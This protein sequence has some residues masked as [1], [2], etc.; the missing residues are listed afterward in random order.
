MLK[1][2]CFQSVALEKTLEHPLDSKDM[3]PISL[4]GNQLWIFIGRTEAEASTLCPPDVKG[5]LNGKDFDNRREWGQ[6]EKGGEEDEMVGWHH[7]LNVHEFEQILGDSEG[8]EAWGAALHSVAKGR[9][10]LNNWTTTS[11]CSCCF[12]KYI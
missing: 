9:T 2:W 1:N 8:Q 5:R 11:S 7:W 10:D 12:A 4:K 6:I 3:K